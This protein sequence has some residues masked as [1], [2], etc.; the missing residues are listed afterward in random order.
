MRREKSVT[1]NLELK[2][3]DWQNSVDSNAVVSMLQSYALHPMGGAEPLSEYAIKNLPTA[4]AAT[5]GAFSVIAWLVDYNGAHQAVGLA[6][7]FTALSTFACKP[8]INI[9]DLYVDVIA[10][11]Q[12]TG[13]KLLAFVEAEAKERG[14]CKVTL[15]VL[16]GNTNAMDA[17]E[18]FERYKMNDSTGH[19]LFMHKEIN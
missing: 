18:R 9:H 19:A 10:R 13:Q 2:L 7:C 12:G 3:V 8:L 17:Y 4:M 15:E 5:P 11:G 14:C 6:N 1:K 16:T